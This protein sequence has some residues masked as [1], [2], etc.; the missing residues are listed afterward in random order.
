METHMPF[1]YDSIC[2]N[3]TASNEYVSQKDISTYTHSYMHPYKHEHPSIV[4][5]YPLTTCSIPTFSYI[6]H[7]WKYTYMHTITHSGV[8]INAHYCRTADV[9]KRNFLQA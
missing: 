9:I 4:L 5:Y 1:V 6:P 3:G 2:I 8:S 7:D